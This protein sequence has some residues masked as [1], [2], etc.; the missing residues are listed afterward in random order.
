MGIF[1]LEVARLISAALLMEA[2]RL[3][4]TPEGILPSTP[5]LDLIPILITFQYCF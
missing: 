1:S 5:S 4:T 2:P 3:A